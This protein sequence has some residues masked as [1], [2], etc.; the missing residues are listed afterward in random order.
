MYLIFGV[1]KT[2]RREAACPV[3]KKVIVVGGGIMGMS[4][5]WKLG[6]LSKSDDDTIE[7]EVIDSNHAIR[8]SFG[9][10]RSPHHHCVQGG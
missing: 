1:L 8:G 7:V 3:K 9:D 6:Q 10:G 2:E 5:A 4:A